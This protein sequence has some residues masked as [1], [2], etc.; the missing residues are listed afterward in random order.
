[1]SPSAVSRIPACTYSVSAEIRSALAICWRISADGRRSPRSIW[2]RYGLEIPASS[3][4]RR[5]E[6]RAEPAVRG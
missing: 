5:S 4:S 2:L 6:S 3:D 1:M